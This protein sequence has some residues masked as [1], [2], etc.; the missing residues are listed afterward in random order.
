MTGNDGGEAMAMPWLSVIVPSH[1]GERWLGAAL[2]S[3]ADQKD[4]GIEVILIDSSASDASLDLARTFADRLSIRAERRLDLLSWTEKTNWGVEEAQADHI[5]MLHQDDLWLPERSKHLRKWL[6]ERPE[7]AMHLHSCYIIDET[8]KRVGLW[9]CPLPPGDP[10]VP[11]FTLWQRLLIQCFV[12]IPTPTIRRDVYLR[13]GGLDNSLWLTADW[14]LYLKISQ[15]GEVYYHPDPLACFRIHQN[16]LTVS[17]SRTS[18]DYRHQLDIV[19]DRHVAQRGIKL[20]KPVLRAAKASIDVNVAL[21]AANNGEFGHLLKALRSMM[22]L[23]PIGMHRYLVC[24][25][26]LERG[27][28][29]LRARLAGKF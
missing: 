8:G 3:I 24:S 2:Q 1:N 5:C 26:I 17:G 22:A 11:P 12:A 4:Q 18:E 27:G 14:D 28:A 16:S 21:A 19:F 7:A 25:R 10:P 29:R 15:I 23:G 6:S 13:A 9:R 20:D